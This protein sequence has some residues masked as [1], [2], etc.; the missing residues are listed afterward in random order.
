FLHRVEFSRIHV[1]PFSPR[2]GTEA[3]QMPDQIPHWV[4]QKRLDIMLSVARKS[5]QSFRRRFLGRVFPVLWENGTGGVLSG[6]TSNYIRVY[7]TGDGAL[8]GKIMP[9]CLESLYRDGV[10]GLIQV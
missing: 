8:A 9:V 2:P 1:F 6:L 3:A 4:K 5:S 7:A 10:R